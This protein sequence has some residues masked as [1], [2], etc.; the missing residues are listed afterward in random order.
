[1]S[2]FTVVSDELHEFKCNRLLLAAR[3]KYYEALFRQEPDKLSSRLDVPK[4]LLRVVLDSLVTP[5]FRDCDLEELLQLLPVVDFL[6]MPDTLNEIETVLSE[7]LDLSNIYHIM[8]SS[9]QYFLSLGVLKEKVGLF[10]QE[11]ILSVDLAR[12][13]REW[14]NA[15]VSQPITNV[16]VK[17]GRYLSV[18]KS[19]LKIAEAL[20]DLDSDADW[21]FSQDSRDRIGCSLCDLAKIN[22]GYAEH[23]HTAANT[24]T[25]FMHIQYG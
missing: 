5:Q 22:F 4:C 9:E 11:N 23:A 21:N 6:Q 2:D 24:A 17:D 15:S 18:H 10:V 20:F 7:K 25:Q 12:V 16:R 13:S 14:I 3:S 1:M 8:A 19:D